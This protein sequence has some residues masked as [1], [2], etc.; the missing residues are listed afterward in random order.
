M[1]ALLPQ[2]VI[3][4]DPT[5]PAQRRLCELCEEP[6]TSG[7]LQARAWIGECHIGFVCPVCADADPELLLTR[8]DR[9]LTDLRDRLPKLER[10]AEWLQNVAPAYRRRSFR[11]ISGS[12]D[13]RAT[14]NR[15]GVT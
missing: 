14:F 3:T 11:V 1:N 6:F 8:M 7:E 5:V 9:Q 15:L 10:A 2:L 4:S 13:R 12:D